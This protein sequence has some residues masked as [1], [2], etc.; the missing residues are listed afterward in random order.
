MARTH[1]KTGGSKKS[2]RRSVMAEKARRLH[3]PY[4]D[5]QQMIIR[6]EWPNQVPPPWVLDAI[7]EEKFW[8][9]PARGGSLPPE[10]GGTGRRPG[11][12]QNVAFRESDGMID[13]RTICHKCHQAKPLAGRCDCDV[14]PGRGQQATTATLVARRWG[15]DEEDAQRLIAH[16][17]GQGKPLAML[18]DAGNVQRNDGPRRPQ[19]NPAI[20][21]WSQ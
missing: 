2:A 11:W 9:H 10:T 4:T 5:A 21:K 3:A 1:K 16:W 17:V 8:D 12:A 7:A 19:G 20:G 18:L 13:R 14:L 15:C 6:T